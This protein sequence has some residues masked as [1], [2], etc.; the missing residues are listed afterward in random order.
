MAHVIAT[1]EDCIECPFCLVSARNKKIA[2]VFCS[3]LDKVVATVPIVDVLK[4][5]ARAGLPKECPYIDD[6]GED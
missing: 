1:F 5:K 3:G 6:N 2:N 4:N